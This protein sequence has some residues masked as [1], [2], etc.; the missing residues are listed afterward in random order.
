MIGRLRFKSLSVNSVDP[1][2]KEALFS[3]FGSHLS[4]HD[5]S[6]P[7]YATLGI[8]RTDGTSLPAAL[9]MSIDTA[10]GLC[11]DLFAAAGLSDDFCFGA[12]FVVDDRGIGQFSG[13]GKEMGADAEN[14]AYKIF[15]TKKV[16]GIPT[17][18]NMNPARID[19]G[20]SIPWNYEYICFTIDN[21]GIMDF[22]WNNPIEVI[23]TVQQNASL[24]SFHEIIGVFETMV[25]VQYEAE[26]DL[27]TG[28]RGEMDVSIDAIQ[29][30]FVRIHEQNRDGATGLLVPAWVFYG[31]NRVTGADG[32]VIYDLD[33]GTAHSWN[34][35][36]YPV[37]IINAIDG[38]L[39]DLESGY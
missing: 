35:E 24:K 17:F 3:G 31:N 18:V 11:N 29:L 34:A 6:T 25:K 22:S 2:S 12:A 9:T 33:H 10:L 38:S 30:C 39:I 4:Y 37:L 13:S 1:S 26:T 14:N 5:A 32:N 15:Y 28:G 19:N 27:W 8:Q 23:E 36:P 16:D 7:E 21:N 20:Y